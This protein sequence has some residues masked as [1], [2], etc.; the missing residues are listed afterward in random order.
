MP[1]RSHRRKLENTQSP[2]Q[3]SKRSEKTLVEDNAVVPSLCSSPLSTAD[4]DQSK[5]KIMY[6][7]FVA[8]DLVDPR[9]R[10]NK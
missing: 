2:C 6:P 4:F 8:E 9:D 5:W 1:G 7:H 10:A 3:K